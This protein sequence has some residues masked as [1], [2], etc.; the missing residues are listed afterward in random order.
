MWPSNIAKP[1]MNPM[2]IINP[3]SPDTS[4]QVAGQKRKEIQAHGQE[5][6][7]SSPQ[8]SSHV[9]D[10]VQGI[11]NA[12]SS[13]ATMRLIFRKVGKGLDQKT[14]SWLPLRPRYRSFSFKLTPCGRGRGKKST[15]IPIKGLYR[16]R[17]W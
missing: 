14:P 8:R 1:L 4:T 6:G 7:L 16:S 3:V 11:A 2:I 12:S 5:K 13:D 10:L 9:R 17:K 15:K